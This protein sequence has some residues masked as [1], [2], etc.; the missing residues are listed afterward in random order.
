MARKENKDQIF[1]R[2]KHIWSRFFKMLWKARLP[3]LWIAI[4]IILTVVMVNM[5]LDVTEYTSQMFAGNLSLAGVIIPWLLYTLFNIVI[6]GVATM[7]DYLCMARVDRNL[8]RMVWD[9]VTRLPMGYFNHNQPKELLTRITSDTST[10]STLLV[11]VVLPFFT[12]FYTL[13]ATFR[14]VG[15]YDDMLMWSLLLVVPFVL[16]VAFIMGKLRFG[17]ND[18]VNRKNAELAQ[19]V[20][21]KVT[22]IPLIKAFAN[23][24]KEYENGMQRMR[25]TYRSNLRNSWIVNLSSPVHTIVGTL[26]LILI[27]LVGR[28]FYSSGAITLAQWIAYLAFAQQIANTLQG[29]AGY[30]DSFKASQG[31]TRRVTYIMDEKNE[32]QGPDRSAD[33]MAGDVAFEKVS[34]GYEEEN[35]ISN[36][37]LTI[38]EGKIT[39]LIGPSGSGKT[40]LLNLLERFYT[41][42]EGCITIGGEDIASYNLK[43][44]RENIA[45]VTQESALLGGSIRENILYGISRTVSQEELETAARSANAYDFIMAFPEGF[46]APVGENGDKLSGG[47]KQRIAIA[48]ALLKQPKLLLLDEATAAMD[49]SAKEEIWQGLRTL[50]AGKTTLMVAHDYQTVRNADV[51]VVME[52]GRIQDVG[53]KE[54]LEERNSFY[55]Q[56]AGLEEGQ[57]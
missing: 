34:F 57:V 54:E 52:N 45:Y 31:A 18:E 24:D 11:Q 9:K 6:A 8:R 53:T 20:S 25:Q 28:S 43:S 36:L 5:S 30:W 21:E 3:Y 46:D 7:L 14:K 51:V 50:M 35:I 16:V 26:Q 41:P 1:V 47:Q 42:R 32:E 22:N 56:L 55:R 29:Y 23:E 40:T 15:G 33:D 48:R 49:I 12:G 44:F 4:Y 19:E 13:I 27:V 37:S 38:P 2:D 39:A 17:I 10:I